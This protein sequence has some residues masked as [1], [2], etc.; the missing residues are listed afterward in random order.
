MTWRSSTFN[1][2][3]LYYI[4]IQLGLSWRLKTETIAYCCC[5]SHNYFL[6]F[7]Y[8]LFLQCYT[9]LKIWIQERWYYRKLFSLTLVLI[10]CLVGYI[11]QLRLFNCFSMCCF[12]LVYFHPRCFRRKLGCTLYLVEYIRVIMLLIYSI[13]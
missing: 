9:T 11:H 3:E 1:L 12:I 6:P 5:I 10:L 2:V 8:K 13:R 7:I 4:Y